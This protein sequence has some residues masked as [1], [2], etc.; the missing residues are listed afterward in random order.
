MADDFKTTV[1]RNIDTTDRQFTN[2]IWQAGK[3]P[4]DSELNFVGQIAT[5]NLATTISAN[6]HSGILMNPRS[7]DRGF[8]FNPLWS[9]FLKIKPFKALV[10]GLVINVEEKQLNLSP[11]PEDT[12]TRVDFVF[13]EVWKTIISASGLNADLLTN[14][15]VDKT[16]VY[17]NGDVE[18]VN[19]LDDQMVDSNVGFETT[20]RVQVQY[21]FR[22]VD[23]IN[24][25]S[26]LE[27]MSSNLVKAQGPLSAESDVSF[28]NQH[29]NG[30]AGLWVADM[31]ATNSPLLSENVIYGLP[32]C[33]I[34]RRNDNVYVAS[35]IGGTNQN[36]SV[37]R[38]PSSTTSSNA[39]TLTQATLTSALLTST[40]SG[41]LS[42]DNGVGSGLDDA[43]LYGSNRYLV[44][45]EGL[46]K[47]IIRVSGF[48]TPNLT[49][50]SRGQGGT[51]VKYHPL[52]TKVSLYNNRPDGKYADQIHQ[53][54]V[55]D[56]RHATTIGEWDYQSLLESSLSD[57]LFGNLNTAYKQNYLNASSSGITIEEV[58]V[59]DPQAD[60]LANVHSMDTAN[61]FRD[62]WSDASVPQ[63][64][65]TMYLNLSATDTQG[66]TTTNLNDAN[67]TGWEVGPDLNPNAFIY[68]NSV[69]RSGSWIKIDLNVANSNLTLGVNSAKSPSSL[70]DRGV[71]FIAPKEMRDVTTKRPP[72]TIEEL[73]E[74]HGKLHY[75]TSESNFEKPFIVLGG[76]KQSTSVTTKLDG[77]AT[78]NNFYILYEPTAANQ[79]TV[80]EAQNTILNTEDKV[81]AIR[82]GSSAT[83]INSN[84][85]ALE[86]L[87]T[88][89]G[90]DT[91][92]NSSSLYAVLYGD[93]VYTNN[94]S[95]VFK[96]VRMLNEE[97][98]TPNYDTATYYTGVNTEWNPTSKIGFIILKPIDNINRGALA[99]NK[100]LTLEFRTQEITDTDTDIMIAITESVDHVGTAP[101]TTLGKLYMDPTQPEF[102]LSVSV[103]YP[104]TTG[105]TAN[106][107]KNIHKIGLVPPTSTGE[108]LN[109]S[110]SVLQGTNFSDLSL[111]ENEI[112]LPTKNHVSLW[113]RLPSSNL[114]IGVAQSTQ[115]GGRIINEEAD[116]EAEAF[117]D[118]LSKTVVFRPF[119]KKSFIIHKATKTN[120]EKNG[121]TTALIPPTWGDGNGKSTDPNPHMFL[122]TKDAA[123]VLPE[124]LMPRFGRQDIPLHVYTTGTGDQFRNGLNHMFID[125]PLSSSDQVFSIIGG[126]DN[127]NPG[128]KNILFVT[129]DQTASWGERTTLNILD[130]LTGIA[131]KKTT[132]TIPSSDFG[133][134]LRGIEL[135]P[136]YGIARVYG[137]YHT[138]LFK[139]HLD[140]LA[141][142]DSNR[143][144]VANNVSMCPN[145]LRTDTSDFTMY[146][147][148][149]GGKDLVNGDGQSNVGYKNAHTYMLTEHAIDISRLQGKTL[150]DGSSVGWSENSTFDSFEYVIEAVVF[151]FADGFIT[152]NRYV[153]PRE[154]NGSGTAQNETS[155]SKLT[156][157]CVVPF[158]PP[159]GSHI[160]ISSKRTPYQGDPL[161]T[162]SQ[163]DQTIPQGRKSLSDL[164]LGTKDQ[165]TVDTSSTKRRNVEVL[166]SMDFY[167]TLGTGKIGGDVYPTTI[168]DVGYTPFPSKRNPSS[169]EADGLTHIPLKT[170]TFT[171]E[172]TKRGGWA[173]LFLFKG[174]ES[175]YKVE[176][177]IVLY[178]NGT[179]VL[180]HQIVNNSIE[181]SLPTLMVAIQ[182]KGFNCFQTKGEI[183][184]LGSANSNY[185]GILTQAPNPTDSFEIEV[186]W[187]DLRNGQDIQV[188]EGLRESPL[189]F[190]MLNSIGTENFEYALN[191]RSTNRVAFSTV[192]IAPLNAGD[193]NT[194]I[195][196]TG[197]TSRLPLGS[198]V[199]DS[200]FVCEDILNDRSSYLF[201]TTGSFST[202]SN[203]V[204]VSP[205]GVP[206]TATLG[207]SGDVIQINDGEIF[208]STNPASQTKYTIAR[209]GGSVFGVGGDVPGGPLSFLS[210]SYG[211]SLQPVL[212]GSALAGRAML[213]YNTYEEVNGEAKSFGSELQLVVVTHAIDGGTS[214]ITL[215]GDI[216]PSGYG[217]GF[218]SADRFR[219]KGKPLAKI[220]SQGTEVDVTPAPYNS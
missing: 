113:N 176:A 112:D 54:D 115:M 137:V 125:K 166:A 66:L 94:N 92:G 149:D 102:Q 60:Q 76:L 74:R 67:A 110:K 132:L 212:K 55:F 134:T 154:H 82:P 192:S 169:L 146:I 141:G 98:S 62:T 153:L 20:K 32:I 152:H 143:V 44:L 126:V 144:N 25:Y 23:S 181:D 133:S 171:S 127:S 36:G 121:I 185:F 41:D 9:N 117:T 200:D 139:D 151:M 140:S 217:E 101:I 145:L 150:G 219:I 158:A 95:G 57:L 17:A 75:P 177:T 129:G 90:Y 186:Q 87:V 48:S 30:D 81:I 56:M 147:R 184:Q 208:N 111:V 21:R 122:D 170:S 65:L 194:P 109:N 39:I 179:A 187:R 214:S 69:M 161:N 215:G 107:S 206:Y 34:T 130:G 191:S 100:N 6:A 103:L 86:S 165:S 58:S 73:G 216:S 172:S 148:K 64:G 106:V 38:K 163:L 178:K 59:I 180:T 72:F 157:D 155:L 93:E 26:H 91:S 61:G 51:Q 135:P 128:V 80:V 211:E 88:N 205:N 173:S 11:P 8:S 96:V 16:K 162:L 193:G 85:L 120:L 3:P 27:G 43:N 218:A 167:T 164:Q 77:D 195:S 209:G 42:I 31:T 116:R 198:L 196:L 182:D 142:H 188:F 70:S 99:E 83:V 124:Q 84:I 105:A 136:Y 114:P 7:S 156:V 18:G 29:A 46:N 202:L 131:S 190:Q 40:E 138:G 33:A 108:F 47:E 14:K 160:T 37:D 2:V 183:N 199:R 4:L 53:D 45:G 197:I 203:P 50:V 12:G 89:N 13:L 220:Y 63:M 174:A 15:P 49:L 19:I 119:Q 123:F 78:S 35:S 189:S 207:I 118:E 201:S 22:V 213:V 10:N 24:I 97:T 1:S 5:D 68:E 168:T 204:P 175:F 28:T 210:T 71:R 159:T 104:P 79:S 52:G